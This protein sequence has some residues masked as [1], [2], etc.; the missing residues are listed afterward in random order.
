MHNHTQGRSVFAYTA[1]ATT[2]A[3]YSMYIYRVYVS[4]H[5]HTQGRSLFA[6]TASAA[7]TAAAVIQQVHMQEKS[8]RKVFI[9][10]NMCI[11]SKMCFSRYC[12]VHSKKNIYL[13]YSRLPA[14]LIL[15]PTFICFSLPNLRRGECSGVGWT[16]W[17][18][19]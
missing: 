6:Y 18:P 10:Q 4:M 12:T 14:F 7:T 3:A 15:T 17:T 19:A 2:A 9:K 13:S 8:S 16:G 5:N 11:I 1:S